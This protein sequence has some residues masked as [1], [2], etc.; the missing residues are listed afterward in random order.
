MSIIITRQEGASF[1]RRITIYAD[2]TKVGDIKPNGSITIDGLK[3]GISI[4]AKLDW[5]ES[6]T[7]RLQENGEGIV[8]LNLVE[9]TPLYPTA[10]KVLLALALVVSIFYSIIQSNVLLYVNIG[11][12]IYLSFYLSRYIISALSKGQNRFLYLQN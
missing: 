9:F 8:K 6:N 3:T 5:I 7:V 1:L 4:K 11:L 10:H 2:D 12:A